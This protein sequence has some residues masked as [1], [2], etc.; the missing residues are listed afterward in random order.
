[1]ELYTDESLHRGYRMAV[2]VCCI[3]IASAFMYAAVA[4]YV[5]VHNAP[6]NGLFRI[7]AAAYRKL[8]FLL[9]VA[10][11]VNLALIPSLR[12]HILRVAARPRAAMAR[13]PEPV[14]RV[15]RASVGSFVLCLSVAVY[16]LV[17]FIATGDRNLFYLHFVL[18][19]TS[20]AI[21][22]PRLDRW[23]AWL[24]AMA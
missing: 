16:G 22:F 11:L 15:M 21:H 8:R 24:Q 5:A 17:I 20:F 23:Q 12:N 18:A 4:E 19:L 2:S 1:M 7:P 3:M 9:P 6:F 13:L 14:L 10:A